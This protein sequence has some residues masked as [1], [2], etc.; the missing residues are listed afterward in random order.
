[1]NSQQM[2]PTMLGKHQNAAF[3]CFK[4]DWLMLRPC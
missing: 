1:M 4:Y 2:Q 3:E